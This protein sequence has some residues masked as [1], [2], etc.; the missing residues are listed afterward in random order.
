MPPGYVLTSPPTTD[1]RAA[2]RAVATMSGHGMSE[3]PVMGWDGQH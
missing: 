1:G 2:I 3:P